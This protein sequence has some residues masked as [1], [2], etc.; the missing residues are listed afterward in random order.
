M[1]EGIPAL[2]QV[3]ES[4]APVQAEQVRSVV[5]AKIQGGRRRLVA[6]SLERL[7]VNVRLAR[8]LPKELDDALGR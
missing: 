6:Q 5:G 2:A 4:G 3:D 7:E 8:R 1:L